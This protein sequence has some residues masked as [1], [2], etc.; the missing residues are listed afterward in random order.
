MTTM[1][2]DLDESRAEAVCPGPENHEKKTNGAAWAHRQAH[3][4]P[5][6]LRR[7]INPAAWE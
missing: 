7:V 4:A 3:V 1:I 2:H 6:V 5:F